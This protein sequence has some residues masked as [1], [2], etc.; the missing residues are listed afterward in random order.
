MNDPNYQKP[1]LRV[2]ALPTQTTILFIVICLVIFM[3]VGFSLFSPS[4]A[5]GLPIVLGMLLLPLRDFLRQPDREIEGRGLVPLE[6]PLF[7]PLAQALSQLGQRIGLRRAP[8]L[9]LTG[10]SLDLFSFGSARRRYIALDEELAGKLQAELT[11]PEP[12]RRNQVETLLLHEL[13][14]FRNQDIGMVR[15][16]Y[17]LLKIC[18]I[19]MVWSMSVSAC[20][21]AFM[22]QNSARIFQPEF[23]R[24]FMG[25]TVFL[26]MLQQIH[27]ELVKRLADPSI[28][29]PAWVSFMFFI[30]ASHLPFI[31]SGVVLLL[32]L[33]RR[34]LRVRE[35]YADA[36]AADC[37]GNALLVRQ[38]M[39]W[40]ATLLSLRKRPPLSWWRKVWEKL[41][42]PFQK[43]GKT[44]GDKL[45]RPLALHP[46]PKQRKACLEDP[47]EIYGS[48]WW[49]ATTAGIAV[50]LLD[51]I[52][53]GLFTAPHVTN[54]GAHLPF[55]LGFL[56]ISLS[57]LPIL[58]EG[59]LS[60][61]Q[62]AIRIGKMVGLFS[63]ITLAPRLL[64]GIGGMVLLIFSPDSLGR[65]MDVYLSAILGL[66]VGSFA[67]ALGT[68]IP[69]TMLVDFQI[70]RP[71]LYYALVMP[72]ILM[73]FL[74]LDV[75][76][77][78]LTLTWY[79]INEPARWLVRSFWGETLVFVLLLGGGAIP[80]SSKLVFPEVYNLSSLFHLTGFGIVVLVGCL[81][82]GLWA[83]SH[84]RYGGHCPCGA[85][86]SGRFFLGKRC[87]ACKEL[88]HSWLVANY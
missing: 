78:R 63:L 82:G 75:Y 86:V 14:H 12:E 85:V 37:L 48:P 70:V 76:F 26:E 44:L 52:L 13:F 35:L 20:G 23:F 58:C 34:L 51:F 9:R 57:M 25:S 18:V 29:V 87:P 46:T 79:G 61:K 17:G 45:G 80:L 68:E 66:P 50:V 6:G 40:Y 1:K 73:G 3:A 53:R 39:V 74:V 22:I 2:L 27:P 10:K 16:S 30:V 54:P 24:D 59:K 33:W 4:P 28:A 7:V 41:W 5:C 19:F 15:Y 88:L 62:L 56:V 38:A 84:R 8:C 31:F 65:M 83:W 72:P 42:Q 43:W 67:D 77:K 69:W 21:I 81:A 55:L 36:G 32:F 47:S 60:G 11:A 49:G 64:D 71:I